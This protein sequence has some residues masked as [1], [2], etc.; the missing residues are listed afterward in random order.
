MR[1]RQRRK[2]GLMGT[3][4][5]RASQGNSEGAA[6]RFVYFDAALSKLTAGGVEICASF[7]TVKLGLTA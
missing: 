7:C 1:A 2:V 6:A 3:F 5:S 4:A